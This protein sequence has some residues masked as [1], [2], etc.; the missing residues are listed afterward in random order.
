MSGNSFSRFPRRTRET[1]LAT[2]KQVKYLIALGVSPEEANAMTIKQ[3]SAKIDELKR[4]AHQR[5]QGGRS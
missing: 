3:A 4:K 1:A 5:G 2:N